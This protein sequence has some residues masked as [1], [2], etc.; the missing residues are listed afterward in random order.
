MWELQIT[1][2]VDWKDVQSLETK[3]AQRVHLDKNFR[4]FLVS[5]PRPT[6][7]YGLSS[8]REDLLWSKETLEARGIAVEKA[9]R[10]G[11]W[12]FHGPGQ[13]VIFP[14]LHL[15][16]IGLGRREVRKFIETTRTALVN[17]LKSWN[18][19]ATSGDKPYGIYVDQK[20]IASFG[21]SFERGVVKHGVAIYYSTQNE[22]LGGIHP[23][24]VPDGRT[25]SLTEL[26]IR[27]D[28]ETAA[29]ACVDSLKSSFQAY[30]V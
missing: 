30:L 18:I 16:S 28:W 27:L 24:G 4:T 9:G 19:P 2:D 17:L 11:Q 21:F 8:S 23:C 15:E 5:E 1:R 3:L 25:T 7:T 22:F 13:I 29:R 10:G 20:K 26:G 12:T 6:Y 14:I